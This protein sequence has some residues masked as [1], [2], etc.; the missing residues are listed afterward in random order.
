MYHKKDKM[1]NRLKESERLEIIF[2]LMK[3]VQQGTSMG[4]QN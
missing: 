3:D 1:V 2:I 4:V